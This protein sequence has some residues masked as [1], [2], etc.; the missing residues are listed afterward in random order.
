MPWNWNGASNLW[1][2]A[3]ARKQKR[4]LWTLKASLTK[5]EPTFLEKNLQVIEG[6]ASEKRP[7]ITFARL[8][9]SSWEHSVEQ[10]IPKGFRNRIEHVRLIMKQHIELKF[11]FFSFQVH[12]PFHRFESFTWSETV[13]WFSRRRLFWDTKGG[14][15]AWK[16]LYKCV[17]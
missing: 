16:C 11:R 7:K 9:K 1:C 2:G 3:A 6:R 10:T 5:Q 14:W 13:D 17:T 4:D 15:E 12:E 8:N